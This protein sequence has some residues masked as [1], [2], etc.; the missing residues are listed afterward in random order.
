MLVHVAHQHALVPL[1][2]GGHEASGAGD[3]GPVGHALVRPA[4]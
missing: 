2:A 3:A 4:C 1:P